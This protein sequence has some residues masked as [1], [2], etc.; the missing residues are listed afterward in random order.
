[1]TDVDAF[2]VDVVR[3]DFVGSQGSQTARLS[4]GPPATIRSRQRAV[5]I[6]LPPL[7]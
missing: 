4:V 7:R 2:E 5:D 1:V 3:V 6:D